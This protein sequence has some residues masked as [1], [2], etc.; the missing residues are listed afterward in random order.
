MKKIHIIGLTILTCIPTLLA[1]PR[2]KQ[3][4]NPAIVFMVAG[5]SN[6]GG[7]GVYSPEMHKELGRDKARPLVPGT[8]ASEI[9]LPTDAAAYTHSYI[10]LPKTGFER[11]DPMV[12][13][14]PD[15]RG[16]KMHGMEL[17]MAHRLEKLFPNNDIYLIKHGPSGRN[18]YHDWNPAIEHAHYARWLEFT[19]KGLSQLSS[20]YPEV[21]VI[22]LYWDQGESDGDHADAYADNLA[23]LI[24]TFRKDAGI[25]E[26]KVFIRKHIYRGGAMDP[27]IAAQEKVAANDSNAFLLDIELETLEKNYGTWSYT[28]NNIHINSKA[29]VELAKIL[30]EDVLKNPGIESFDLCT[31]PPALVEDPDFIFTLQQPKKDKALLVMNNGDIELT[32]DCPSG[33]GSGKLIR[34]ANAE[35]WPE[36]I[37]LLIRL[38]DGKPLAELEGFTVRGKQGE[39]IHVSKQDPGALKIE[40]TASAMKVLIPGKILAGESEVDVQ[41]IDFHR[42]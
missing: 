20:E 10:W 7:C 32:I 40:K 11:L 39:I 14:R 17:P 13:T 25:P 38:D 41:W 3:T 34:R 27:I 30:M 22:G 16:E 23:N 35:K 26:L 12:N 29:F 15:K 33:I 42:N 28:P 1:A 18:L 37:T 31:A 21:R 6:A 19:S 9:G 8:T 2:E 24:A 36:Q 4:Q 5:Q